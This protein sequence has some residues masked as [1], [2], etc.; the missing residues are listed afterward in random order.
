MYPEQIADLPQYSY[1]E[2]LIDLPLCKRSEVGNCILFSFPQFI[3]RVGIEAKVPFLE[4]HRPDVG[5]SYEISYVMNLFLRENEFHVYTFQEQVQFVTR[6][7][8]EIETAIE[9][10]QS[11]FFEKLRNLQLERYRARDP[12]PLSESV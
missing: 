5:T 10:N 8:S 11:A 1:V 4:I 7:F 2:K 3:L 9:K 6:S 12:R